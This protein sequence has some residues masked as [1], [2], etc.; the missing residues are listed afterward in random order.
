MIACDS[1]GANE[2]NE[3]DT[4]PATAFVLDEGNFE[5]TVDEDGETFDVSGGAVFGIATNLGSAD[6]GGNDGEGFVLYMLDGER[7]PE[8]ERSLND[9]WT[10]IRITGQESIVP[11]EGTYEFESGG[12]TTPDYRSDMDSPALRIFIGGGPGEFT[13]TSASAD[14]LEGT[15]NFED[16]SD[17]S[18]RVQGSFT[19]VRADDI[20][21][22]LCTPDCDD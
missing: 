16:P 9:T 1:G 5:A 13:I 18:I 15:F 4:D 2:A 6:G 12:Y 11:G 10:S 20:D 3:E 17:G 21:A 19:A 22:V 7:P 8:D 14:E